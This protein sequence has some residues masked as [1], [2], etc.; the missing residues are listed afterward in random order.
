MPVS[1]DGNVPVVLPG[2]LQVSFGS[3]GS[4]AVADVE[5]EHTQ[6]EPV[7]IEQCIRHALPHNTLYGIAGAP[8]VVWSCLLPVLDTHQTTGV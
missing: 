8:V 3:G 1:H 4:A 7:I 6:L 2:G 5:P